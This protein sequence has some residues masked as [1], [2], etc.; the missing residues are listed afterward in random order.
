MI[1]REVG[2]GFV[3]NL[4]PMILH[5]HHNFTYAQNCFTYGFTNYFTYYFTYVQVFYIRPFVYILLHTPSVSRRRD[6]RERKKYVKYMF[7]IL[8]HTVLTA[9]R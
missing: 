9:R 7:Y 2:G 6:A 1:C 8:L 3:L 5:T 4:D